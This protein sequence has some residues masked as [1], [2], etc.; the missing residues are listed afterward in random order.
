MRPLRV[1]DTAR[2]TAG[3]MTSI[4]GTEYRSRASRSIAALAVLQAITSA[5]TPASTKS[6]KISNAKVRTSAS[7]LGP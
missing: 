3:W 1:A 6:S 2:R 5:L 7:G 4:T